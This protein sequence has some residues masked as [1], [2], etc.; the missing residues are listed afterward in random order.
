LVLTD[1][2]AD[3]VGEGIDVAIRIGELADSALIT[4]RS[5]FDAGLFARLQHISIAMAL[6]PRLTIWRRTIVS[7]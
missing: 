3:V 2:V 1:D 4:R 6:P 7:P 5:V